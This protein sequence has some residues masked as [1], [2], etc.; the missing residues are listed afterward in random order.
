MRQNLEVIS[1]GCRV[2]RTT[3]VVDGAQVFLARFFAD[4]DLPLWERR[5]T[6]VPARRAAINEALSNADVA[7]ATMQSSRTRPMPDQTPHLP[8]P[9]Y[10]DV[11]DVWAGGSYGGMGSPLGESLDLATFADRC[12][13]LIHDPRGGDEIA[14]YAGPSASV[15]VVVCYW[16]CNA[17]GEPADRMAWSFEILL[18]DCSDELIRY[19]Q[20]VV[21]A[22]PPA[23]AYRASWKPASG[24]DGLGAHTHSL[25]VG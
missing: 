24:F 2:E 18:S 6:S 20:N 9:F 17:Y 1:N 5:F 16:D 23:A 13:R 22:H 19:V 25:T 14:V 4:G 11:L 12:G 15:L 21:R 8:A 7:L 10:D 3:I